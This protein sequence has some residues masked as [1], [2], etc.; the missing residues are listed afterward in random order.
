VRKGIPRPVE[1]LMAATGLLVLSPLLLVTAAVVM[2]GSRGPVLFR[3]ERIGRGG[4]PFELIKF[5]TMC[6][7]SNGPGVTA[8]NDPRITKVGG[9]LRKLKLDE[10]P[11]LAN[12]LRGEMSF[13]GPRPEVPEYVQLS[14]PLWR[15]VLEARP[16]LTDPVTLRLRNEEDLLADV[17]TDAETFY[18][19]VLQP[20]KLS[21]YLEY[22]RSRSPGSDLRIL[23]LT[24]LAVVLPGR[25]QDPELDDLRAQVSKYPDHGR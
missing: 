21:G 23:W 13:V 4:R 25:A 12:I 6:P 17:R 8:G 10:L 18:L 3:Q 2:L 9:I 19:E 16:G 5:R 15:R 20:Y 22:L 11:E 14:N 24:F 1:I 7:E